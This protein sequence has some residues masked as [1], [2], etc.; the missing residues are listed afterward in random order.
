MTEAGGLVAGPGYSSALSS[1]T[2]GAGVSDSR[3]AT[4]KPKSW[5]TASSV[6]KFWRSW[7]RQEAKILGATTV[8]TSIRRYSVA[9]EEFR[10]EGLALCGLREVI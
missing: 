8:S 1:G 2:P 3:R 4:A 10:V 6:S 7:I 9:E 5:Q